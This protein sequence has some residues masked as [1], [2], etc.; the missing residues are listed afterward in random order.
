MIHTLMDTLTTSFPEVTWKLIDPNAETEEESFSLEEIIYPDCFK[1]IKGKLPSK[2][3]VET[4][5][6]RLNS[7]WEAQEYARQRASAYDSVGNQLDQ[8]MRDM[9]DG[10]K[11]H[12]T[13]CEAV[14]S[15]FP[16]SG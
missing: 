9:R 6:N 7:E 11:T 1:V 10:T 12:Q 15:K 14:K 4:E 3:E 8:L 16:K 13:A 2:S 5:M